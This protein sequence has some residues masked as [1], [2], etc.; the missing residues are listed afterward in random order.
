MYLPS[1]LPGHGRDME[2]RYQVVPGARLQLRRAGVGVGD[3]PTLNS[4]GNVDRAERV[5]SGLSL[6]REGR[7]HVCLWD[8]SGWLWEQN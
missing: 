1:T 6:C 7:A 8:T 2:T 3:A 4:R 5:Q